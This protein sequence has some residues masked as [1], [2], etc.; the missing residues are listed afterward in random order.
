MA[1]LTSTKLNNHDYP[2]FVFQIHNEVH[3]NLLAFFQAATTTISKQ[4][5]II[6]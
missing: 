3:F 5:Q 6:T 4:S 1:K 2:T